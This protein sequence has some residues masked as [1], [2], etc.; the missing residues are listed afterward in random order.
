MNNQ[1][2][3]SI[4][5]ELLTLLAPKG[6]TRAEVEKQLTQLMKICVLRVER[7]LLKEASV[8]PQ[9]LT[10]PMWQK[11]L[12]ES[13]ERNPQLHRRLVQEFSLLLEEYLISV[14]GLHR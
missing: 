11:F 7:D 1:A 6:F 10:F 2:S 12:K 3:Q 8:L 13:A 4:V 14:H 9:S 5:D